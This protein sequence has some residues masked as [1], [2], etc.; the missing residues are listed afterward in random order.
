MSPCRK[1][2]LPR[3]ASTLPGMGGHDRLSTFNFTS[4]SSSRRT[5]LKP[6]KP[7]P[8]VTRTAFP[9]YGASLSSV[10]ARMPPRG[11]HARH[12]IAS[13]HILCHLTHRVRRMLHRAEVHAREVFADDAQREEG[14]PGEDR[15]HGSEK[16]KPRHAAA[17]DQK[18]DHHIKEGD[19]AH[20]GEE[21][22][23]QARNL[24]GQRAEPGD[25]V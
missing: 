2:A 12:A 4:A 14:C 5:R 22:T 9:E 16:R 18:F 19:R 20:H 24:Q 1:V 23:D 10:M 25:H 8:P 13:L 15:D 11:A 7:S 21:E 3:I 17:F 6:M